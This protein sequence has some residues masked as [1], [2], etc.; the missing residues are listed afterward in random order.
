MREVGA[1]MRFGAAAAVAAA[2]IEV[3]VD[4][5]QLVLG[6]P[7]PQHRWTM[8]RSQD[9]QVEK[10]EWDKDCCRMAVLIESVWP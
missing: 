2:E 6:C 9:P 3:A 1:E 4:T 5:R 8:E 7:S 10:L